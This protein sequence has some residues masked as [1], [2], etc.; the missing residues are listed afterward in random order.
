M[1]SLNFKACKISPIQDFTSSNGILHLSDFKMW[2]NNTVRN[3]KAAGG[4]WITKLFNKIKM[5]GNRIP[6]LCNQTKDCYYTRAEFMKQVVT[7]ATQA[8][9]SFKD[10]EPASNANVKKNF[11]R[12]ENDIQ[13]FGAQI[14]KAV[15]RDKHDIF[16]QN[17]LMEFPL[18][19]ILEWHALYCSYDPRLNT[20]PTTYWNTESWTSSSALEKSAPGCQEYQTHS[21]T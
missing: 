3:V 21:H 1:T 13:S 7:L 19:P 2:R 18:S 15:P 11:N 4:T 10:D 5:D 20:D 12:V 17:E 8:G 6:T 9:R 16:N 14:A